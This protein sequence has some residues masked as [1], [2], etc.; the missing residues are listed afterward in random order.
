M[1]TH[2]QIVSICIVLH[3]TLMYCITSNVMYCKVLYCIVSPERHSIIPTLL[4]SIIPTP[5]HS[6]HSNTSPVFY[7]NISNYSKVD[8]HHPPRP[9]KRIPPSP[10]KNKSNCRFPPSS[11]ASQTH[12]TIPG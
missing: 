10:A 11:P 9:H 6:Q 1:S 12:S 5:L 8:F 2:T 4:H 3:C 7:S